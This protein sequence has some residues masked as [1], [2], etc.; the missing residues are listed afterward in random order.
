VCVIQ[1]FCQLIKLYIISDR[2]RQSIGGMIM[3]RKNCS[4]LRGKKS[5]FP[6]QISH[7]VVWNGTSA[8]ALRRQHLNAYAMAWSQD[9]QNKTVNHVTLR[10]ICISTVVKEKQQVLNIITV[11]LYSCLRYPPCKS[12]LSAP[13]YIVICG[14]SASTTSVYISS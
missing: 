7:E 14:L 4:T 2:Q 11:C 1:Q 6:Q 12:Q 5:T 10:C 13:K 8:S 3:T 9:H